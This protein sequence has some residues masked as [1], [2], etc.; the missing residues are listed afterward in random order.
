MLLDDLQTLR[1][2]VQVDSPLYEAL[3]SARAEATVKAATIA[4]STNQPKTL[5]NK[6]RSYATARNCSRRHSQ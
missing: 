6:T 5:R 3:K 4:R 1:R 2:R